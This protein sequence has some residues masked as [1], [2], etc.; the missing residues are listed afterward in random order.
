MF[1]SLGNFVVKTHMKKINIL[2]DS[3]HL[4]KLGRNCWYIA[5]L[6]LCLALSLFLSGD[7]TWRSVAQAE[8]ISTHPDPYNGADASM[9]PAPWLSLFEANATSDDAQ[10]ANT[11]LC[12]FGVNA[13]NGLRSYPVDELRM[14]WYQNYVTRL[15]PERPNGMDFIQTIRLSQTG[16]DSYSS[17]PTTTVISQIAGSNP[18]AAWFVGNEPDRKFFQDDIEPHVYAKAYHDL[19]RVIKAADPTARVFAGSIVQPTPLRLMY[20]DKILTA[21]SDKYHKAMPVDG[22]SIHNFILNEASC[23]VFPDINQCWG[24]D[25]P[26][27]IDASEGLRIDVQ[28]NDNLDLFIEQVERFRHWMWLNGYRDTPLYLSEYGVLMPQQGFPEFNTERVGRFMRNTFDYL[29]TATHSEHGYPPDGNRLV[30]RFS[31]FSI[32][33]DPMQFNGNLFDTDSQN[34]TGLGLTYKEY[35]NAIQETVDFLPVRLMNPVVPLHDGKPIT[36]TLTAQIANSGNGLASQSVQVRFYNGDPNAGGVQIGETQSVQVAGCGKTAYAS[37]NW[38]ALGEGNYAV[39]V[40]VSGA[41]D[42]LAETGGALTNN[43]L[44]QDILVISDP[45][46]LPMVDK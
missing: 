22:W 32:D 8:E 18:G 27:G 19:Y 35:T 7:Q 40:V 37:V 41:P 15:N 11:M 42:S 38:P 14:S 16:A 6:L 13:P 4:Q 39:Y 33:Y 46:F 20:L 2:H 31:W 44:S 45:V 23:K 34:F 30:Q 12:R 25:I 5:G 29:L 43:V 17:V 36:F 26:P 24:A 10:Q 1:M 21:Y 28:D 3:R 9:L